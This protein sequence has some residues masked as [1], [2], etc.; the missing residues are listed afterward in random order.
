[1]AK[2]R[3]GATD[4]SGILL[5]DKSPGMTSHDVVDAVRVIS[6]E[7]RVG[8]TGTLDPAAS[9]LMVICVGSATKLADQLSGLDKDYL[10]IIQF[11]TSTTTDDAEGEVLESATVPAEIADINYANSVLAAFQGSIQQLPPQ[12]SAIKQQ[13]V[14]AYQ[15]ARKGKL[16]ELQPREVFISQLTVQIV[17]Y[18]QWLIAASVSKGTYIRSLARDIGKATGCPAHLAEL[19]RTRVGD[20]HITN[21]LTLEA[22]KQQASQAGFASCLSQVPEPSA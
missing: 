21:A 12:Y 3:R 19:R 6:G 11:G 17:D 18:D 7:G 5:I 14:R 1:M 10:G 8:H 16:V 9:G 15:Q 22:L 13:G 4:F 20:Y 2:P